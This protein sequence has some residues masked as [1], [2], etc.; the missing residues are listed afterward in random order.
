MKISFVTP[1]FTKYAHFI[2]YLNMG[3]LYALRIFENQD[4]AALI[5]YI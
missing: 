2:V 4:N 5:Q 3:A 1:R